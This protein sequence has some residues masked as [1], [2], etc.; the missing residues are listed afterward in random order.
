[1]KLVSWNILQGGGRRLDGIIEALTD[2][3]ADIITLQEVR[4]PSAAKIAA[5]L[6]GL[7]LRHSYMSE[8]ASKA[9]NGIFIAARQP[10][11]AGPFLPVDED[12]TGLCHILEAETDGLTLLPVHFPQKGA[13]VPLFEA[14]LADS[15]SLLPLEACLLGDLNCGLPFLDSSEKTFANAKYVQALLDAGWVDLYRQANG[16]AARDFSWISPRTGRGFR[17]DQALASPSFAARLSAVYYDHSLREARLSDHSAL[18]IE[19]N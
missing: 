17:Y 3:E 14:L 18:I 15:A 19:T 6:R 13:Q 5:H 8:T 12:E 7:G 11:E 2:F 1:V 4:A 16:E 9:Q 10:L